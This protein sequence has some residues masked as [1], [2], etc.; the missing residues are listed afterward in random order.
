MMANGPDNQ[1]APLPPK[2]IKL[3]LRWVGKD[4]TGKDITGW[5][6]YC[7][8]CQEHHE[9]DSRWTF[10]GNM[11]QPTFTPSLK[12][13][14]YWRMP[15]GWSYDKAKAEG[16]AENDPVTGRLPGA[17]NWTCHLFIRGGKIEFLGDCTHELKGQTVE[18]PDLSAGDGED[19]QHG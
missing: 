14:P 7:P 3:T 6:F 9:I 2:S 5:I 10:D 17:V 15:P 16:K 1:E 19:M 18:L 8:G 4:I 12:C 13:G 11:E